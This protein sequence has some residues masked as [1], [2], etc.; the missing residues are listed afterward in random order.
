MVHMYVM[1]Y[2]LF[3]VKVWDP[4]GALKVVQ[5]SFHESSEERET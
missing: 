1:N 2:L 5:N 4:S 3:D